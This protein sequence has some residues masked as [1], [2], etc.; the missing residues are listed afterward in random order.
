MKPRQIKRYRRKMLKYGITIWK[1]MEELY[2]S[3]DDTFDITYQKHQF[4]WTNYRY[5]LTTEV[6]N[7]PIEVIAA[8][9]WVSG[10]ISIFVTVGDTECTTWKEKI[11][12]IGGLFNYSFI[13]RYL[14]VQE[15]EMRQNIELI[16]AMVIKLKD[17]V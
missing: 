6:D 2:I 16:G 7:T 8:K 12:I 3:S 10:D 13:E 15:S 1:F 9:E 11:S 14:K 4:P 17:K 5:I